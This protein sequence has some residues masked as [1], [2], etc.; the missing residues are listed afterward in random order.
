MRVREE[1]AMEDCDKEEI[2]NKVAWHVGEVKSVTIEEINES[3][4]SPYYITN[5]RPIRFYLMQLDIKDLF[6]MQ[7]VEDHVYKFFL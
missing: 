2:Q 3:H 7:L 1:K 5:K 6:L 4:Q